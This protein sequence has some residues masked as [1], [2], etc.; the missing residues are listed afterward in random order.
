MFFL[1]FHDNCQSLLV[2]QKEI[3]F[4]HW[5]TMVLFYTGHNISFSDTNIFILSSGIV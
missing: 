2:K 5:P 4:P 1:G 3:I